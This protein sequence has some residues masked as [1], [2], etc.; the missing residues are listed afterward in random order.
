MR[1]EHRYHLSPIVLDDSGSPEVETLAK[2]F[3]FGYLARPNKGEMKK[4]GN[5]KYGFER[6]SG[7]FIIILDA[8]FTPRYDFVDELLPYMSDEKTAIVQS[9][10]FFD[11]NGQ[12][13]RRSWLEYGAGNIQHYFYSIIQQSRN[14][15][16]GSICV[17]SCAL[18][19]RSALQS[20]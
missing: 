13:H 12:M 2:K 3:G 5:L 19:R 1:N 10:Q 18:Y 4:A 17:G 14:T 20:V 7:E 15:F 8:D 16:G 6:T 9:P 11:F